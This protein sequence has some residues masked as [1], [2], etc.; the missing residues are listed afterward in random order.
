MD[1]SCF[2]KKRKYNRGSGGPQPHR[3][4]FGIVERADNGVAGRCLL[5]L[6]PNRRRETLL[7]LIERHI[8]RE[9]KIYSDDYNVYSTLGARGWNHETVNHSLEFVET[10]DR[11]V[12]TQTIEGMFCSMYVLCIVQYVPVK[13]I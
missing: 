8:H 4:V 12:H 6:V 1:E 5:W 13:L 7:P 10:Y 9:S 11:D 3:W 2:S